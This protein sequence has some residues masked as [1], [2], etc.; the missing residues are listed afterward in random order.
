MT[1]HLVEAVN[2]T[3]AFGDNVVL[4]GV[5]LTVD[6][7]E[8]V[9]LLGPSGSGKTTFLRLINQMETLTGGRIRV[10]GELIGVV[11]RKGRLYVRKDRDIARQRSRIGM[12]FQSFNLFP[13]MTILENCTLAPMTARGL[14]KA[15]ARDLAMEYLTK[16]R[17]PDQADKYPSQLSG[18]QQQ[19]VAIA[20][21]LAMQ[22]QIML[23]D[24]PTSALDPEMVQEVL[25]TM[26]QLA[27]EGMT[28]LCV[29]HEMGFARSVANRII[30]MDKGKIVEQATPDVFFT[31]PQTE[32][33][34][35]FLEKIL[36]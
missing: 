16:V 1:G 34:K 8:V 24:E 27:Q 6:T 14:S 21:A 11:E 18:G 19:R 17:I 20:R 25:D 26:K 4:K 35:S 28:M 7:G 5:D 15:A 32:R 31:S 23:F 12:V 22:P 13:H 29:T 9:C 2:V 33:A 36:P 3:K 30:F 10:G